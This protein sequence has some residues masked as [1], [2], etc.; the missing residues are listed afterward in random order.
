MLLFI[1]ALAVA[2]VRGEE[3]SGTNMRQK[4]QAK[5]MDSLP[6]LPPPKPAP[7][8]KD[9]D[10]AVPV[11]VMQPLVVYESRVVRE[12]T[13]VLEREKQNRQ[14]ERFSPLD[15]GKIARIGPVQVGGWWDANEGWTFLRF[16]KGRTRRQAEAAETALKDLEELAALA[17]GHRPAPKPYAT[18]FPSWR[19]TR[20]D[21]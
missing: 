11:V 5:I 19:K 14:D 17:D 7:E 6:P 12:V 1:T 9:N 21:C 20:S 2:S 4:L 16:N 18:K 13:A 8:R 3:A 15:G 10:E